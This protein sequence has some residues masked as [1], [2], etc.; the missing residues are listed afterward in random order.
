MDFGSKCVKALIFLEHNV[1]SNYVMIG[2]SGGFLGQQ[3]VSFN[4]FWQK[5]V[6]FFAVFDDSKHSEMINYVPRI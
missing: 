2:S 1:S 6:D 4:E 5:I 3:G